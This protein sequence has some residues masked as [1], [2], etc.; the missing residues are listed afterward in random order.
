MQ[1]SEFVDNW[2][3]I[4]SRRIKQF[5]ITLKKKVLKSLI[6]SLKP[7]LKSSYLMAD[8]GQVCR[9]PVLHDLDLPPFQNNISSA[10]SYFPEWPIDKNQN[11]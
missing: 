2:V 11:R 6:F 10:S 8:I 7:G 5:I 1:T 9:R 3:A 4:E